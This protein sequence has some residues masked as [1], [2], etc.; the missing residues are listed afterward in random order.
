MPARPKNPEL[1]EGHGNRGTAVEQAR[2]SSRVAKVKPPRC[3]KTITTPAGRKMW[4]GIWDLG[5]TIY[6]EGRDR[7]VIERYVMLQE[8][9]TELVDAVAEQGW[10]VS[11]SQGQTVLHPVARYLA[12]VEAQLVPIEDRLGLSPEAGLR[13]GI[14]A[15]EAE[16]KLEQFLKRGQ[17][18]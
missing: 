11:G 18:G 13:L 7:I 6:V 12:Q 17:D 15:V 9:R 4:R 2:P 10:T 1:R 14:T 16:S 8:R 5:A 3:P